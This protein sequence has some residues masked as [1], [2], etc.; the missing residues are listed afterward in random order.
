MQSAGI[1]PWVYW[2]G[3]NH[4]S[5]QARSRSASD[6]RSSAKGRRA[7]CPDSSRPAS[8]Q[9]GK[10]VGLKI[11]DREKTG[12]FESRFKGLN[13]PSEAEIVAA[14]DHPRIV[15]LLEHGVTTNDEPFLV[16]EFIEGAGLHSFIIGKSK[17]L[18]GRRVNLLRQAAE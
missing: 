10:V 11:L 17:L 14:L 8:R 2:T 4:F 9:S 7:P 16:M 15:K 1:V 6:S 3:L 18:D 13:K 5:G 12:Q